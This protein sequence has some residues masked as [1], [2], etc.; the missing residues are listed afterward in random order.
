LC[1]HEDNAFIFTAEAQ[2]VLLAMVDVK[3]SAADGLL[4][5]SDSLSSVETI[6]NIN[7]SNPLKLEAVSR[8]DGCINGELK[9]AFIWLLIHLGL[10]D[11]SSADTAAKAALSLTAA[12]SPALP[13]R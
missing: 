12:N 3:Q 2:A 10:A 11:N 13:E 4:L 1:L 9:L 5:L 7:L 6:E 8:V